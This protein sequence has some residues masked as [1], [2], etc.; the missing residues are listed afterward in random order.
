MAEYS[1]RALGVH[2]VLAAGGEKSPALAGL[3]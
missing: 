2:K 1:V 3:G